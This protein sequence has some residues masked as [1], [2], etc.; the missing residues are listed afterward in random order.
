MN[1]RY[2]EERSYLSS[3]EAAKYLG[4]NVKA[5]HKLVRK[6]IIPVQIAPSGQ[7]R[8]DLSKLK[9]VKDKLKIPHR[10]ETIEIDII[11][12]IE[13]N[14]TIQKIFVK[15]A[16]KMDDLPDESVHLVITSPTIF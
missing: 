5:L 13:L 14:G 15:N 12:T 7:M 9:E 6:G 1:V 3:V 16:M 4:I 10:N 2:Y 11:N 8:F